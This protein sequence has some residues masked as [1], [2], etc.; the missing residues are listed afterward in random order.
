MRG[1]GESPLFDDPEVTLE[2]CPLACHRAYVPAAVVR[3]E[4]CLDAARRLRIEVEHHEAPAHDP[5][6]PAEHGGGLGV[7]QMMQDARHEG[8]V[9]ACAL[10]QRLECHRLEA[11]TRRS[12]SPAREADV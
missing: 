9:E 12:P 8:L 2:E 4:E 6:E 5:R 7:G 3:E 11:A 1:V 10:G